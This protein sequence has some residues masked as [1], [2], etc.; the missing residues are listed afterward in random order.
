[1]PG[2]LS[3]L[4]KAGVSAALIGYLLTSIDL[5]EAGQLLRRLPPETALAAVAILYLQGGVFALRWHLMLRAVGMAQSAVSVLRIVWIGLFFN[6][7]LPSSVGGDA[8]RIWYLRQSGVGLG[9]AFLGVM[10]E[11]V[12]Q[13]LGL[14]ALIALGLPGLHRMLPDHPLPAVVA[15][16]VLAVLLAVSVLLSF[17]RLFRRWGH[18]PLV[19]LLGRLAVMLRRLF[20]QPLRWL[21][22]LLL[23]ILGH[24]LIVLSIYTLARGLGLDLGLGQALVLVP[25]AMFVTLIPVSVA[26]WGVREGALAAGFGLVGVP[27]EAAIVVSVLF[28]LAAVLQG[29]PGGALWVLGRHRR[30]SLAA[31]SLTRDGSV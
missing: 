13:V 20:A 7:V 28:G 10:G 3:L 16:L 18:W 24:G 23:S 31:Q 12:I 22:L 19:A 15:A 1:M 11:R 27:L 26:G 29:L 8:V 30:S 6:Q 21:L 2:W 17:D 25:L 4:L 5:V 14:S 9:D